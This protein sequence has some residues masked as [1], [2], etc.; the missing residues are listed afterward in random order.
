MPS[1]PPLPHIPRAKLASALK[2]LGV[3]AAILLAGVIALELAFGRWFAPYHPPSGSIFGRTFRG[4]QRVY[5][6]YGEIR[7]VRDQYGLRGPIAAIDQI[8]L[9]TVGGSTTDQTLISEGDTWQDVIHARTGIRLTN[10]GD[11]G[12]SS[13]GHVVAVTEWLHRIP[14]L[15]PR[16]YLHYIGLNDAVYAYLWA[17]PGSKDLIDAQI[18]DQEN[19]RALHRFVRGRSALIQGVIRLRDYFGGPPAIFL[20]PPQ[21]PDPSAPEVRAEADRGPMLEYIRRVYTPNLRRIVDEHRKRGEQVI[22]V[23]QTARPAMF[24]REGE[25]Y[26]VRDPK[27]AHYAVA[28]GLINAAT[29]TFCREAGPDCRFVD[30]ASELVFEDSEFYDNVHTTSAGARRIGVY[31]AEKLLPILRPGEGAA[32]KVN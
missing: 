17:E 8:E 6:P 4:E 5:Q 15:K 9:V 21:Q 31:L 22:F 11:E 7:Y 24:R 30:L 2:L 28:I 13:N 19:R 1:S 14:Q 16:F 32:P 25:V 10:A 23:S 18:A 12:I 29:E 3:N 20:N 26:W 27:V